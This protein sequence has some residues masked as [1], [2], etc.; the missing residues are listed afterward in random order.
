MEDTQYHQWLWETT[1]ERCVKNLRDHAFDAHFFKTRAAAKDAILGMVDTHETFGFG[2]SDTT[3]AIGL[4]EALSA[5]GKTIYDHW[6]KGHDLEQDIDIR[7]QQMTAD[8]FFTSA[9]A[10][11]ATGEV[12]NVDGVG[13][14]TNA[15]CFGPKKVVVVAG[16]NKVRPTLETALA[17]VR[18]VA[19]PMRAKSLDM[20]TPCAKTGVCIDC[21]VPQ[22][23]CRI[24]VIMHRRPALTD[25]SVVLVGEELGF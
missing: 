18:E 10:I 1:A 6:V 2:G 14:R 16:M 23:I 20:P 17:R 8:C 19:G 4:V 9:N 13:N 22:R 3:R 5:R 24:T 12:I 15:M 21:N 11:A 25:V 7:K